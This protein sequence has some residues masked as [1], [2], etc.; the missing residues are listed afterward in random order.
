VTLVAASGLKT[1]AD[2]EP[3]LAA[4]IKAFLIGECLV[5]SPDPGV[6]LRQFI[7]N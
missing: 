4:G 7:K 6:K 2:L 3:L 5:T 1:R